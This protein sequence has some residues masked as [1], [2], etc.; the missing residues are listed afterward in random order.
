MGEVPNPSQEHQIIDRPGKKIGLIWHQTMETRGREEMLRER[1]RIRNIISEYERMNPPL[2]KPGEWAFSGE[3]T[4][5]Q[6]AENLVTELFLQASPILISMVR[7]KIGRENLGDVRG[8]G[9]GEDTFIGIDAI[10]DQLIMDKLDGLAHTGL[11]FLVLSEHST[12]K[13]G[14][15]NIEFILA[16]DPF[17]NSNE[18]MKGIY[19][20]APHLV[21]GVWDRNGKPIACANTNLNSG[22]LSLSHNGKVS[23][24]N[25]ENQ[26]LTDLTLTEE[27]K[28]INFND[29]KFIMSYYTGK[30][31]YRRG[32]NNNLSNHLTVGSLNPIGGAHTYADDILANVMI[33]TE[34]GKNGEPVS[35]IWPGVGMALM[36][37]FK[38]F[39]VDE[40]TGE[41]KDLKFDFQHFLQNPERYS[42]D[43]VPFMI[44]A[45]TLKLARQIRNTAYTKPFP[46]WD[47]LTRAA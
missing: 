26:S 6:K 22:D 33:G 37:G 12:Y 31:K 36:R 32:F 20:I 3:M 45:S 9:E 2:S 39:R 16:V 7:S 15:G 40:N 42:E 38:A 46:E 21:A 4:P 14:A 35:E 27:Q 25:R 41:L 19:T 47:K 44:V 1:A 29:S 18:Y 5:E 34:Q 28:A 24:L 8:R 10:A 17:D 43:R 11:S 13:V 30:E 23:R